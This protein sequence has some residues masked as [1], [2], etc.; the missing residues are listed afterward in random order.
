MEEQVKLAFQFVSDLDKQLITLST[1][2]LA[3][4]ITFTKDI[5]GGIN[6]R[7]IRLL[8]WS[9]IFFLLSITC[10]IW[11]LMALAGT[12]ASGSSASVQGA[13]VTGSNARIPGGAQIITF[14][15]GVGLIIVYGFLSFKRKETKRD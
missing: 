3:L 4:T 5:L 10:G 1:G 7:H 9:W 13:S 6:Q 12:L 2:I 8:L 15:L 11:C 14:I